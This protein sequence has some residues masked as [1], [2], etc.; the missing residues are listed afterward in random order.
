MAFEADGVTFLPFAGEAHV[1]LQT[2]RPTIF[3]LI[4]GVLGLQSAVQADRLRLRG[5]PDDVIRFHEG[6]MLW[7]HGA[8]RSPSFP[9]LL[10]EFRDAAQPPVEER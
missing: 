4:D 8:V 6:L 2:D 3:A 7:L 1:E 9:G 5:G 10:R